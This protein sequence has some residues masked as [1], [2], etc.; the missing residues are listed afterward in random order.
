MVDPKLDDH[1]HRA[2]ATESL[3]KRDAYERA[4]QGT[5]LATIN[6]DP[7]RSALWLTE[8]QRE[9]RDRIQ[10]EVDRYENGNVGFCGMFDYKVT[11]PDGPKVDART[12][13]AWQH[14]KCYELLERGASVE[15]ASV[16]VYWPVSRAQ[17]LYNEF[18]AAPLQ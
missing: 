18:F 7:T 9:T 6:D 17:R 10:R 13:A 8:E 11:L 12:F 16:A 1:W 5:P 14:R 15:E 3:P 2:F 4:I